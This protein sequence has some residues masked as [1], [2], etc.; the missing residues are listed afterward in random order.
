M[1]RYL[2]HTF[3]CFTDVHSLHYSMVFLFLLLSS[4][5]LISAQQLKDILKCKTEH[6]ILLLS[7]FPSTLESNPR[8]LPWPSR[9]YQNWSKFISYYSLPRSFCSAT[10]AFLLFYQCKEHTPPQHLCIECS[11]PNIYTACPLVLPVSSQISP[12]QRGFHYQQQPWY[13]LFPLTHFIIFFGNTI[14]TLSYS[15]LFI[16]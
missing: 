7:D 8:S 5:S 16:I 12:D 2:F 14:T 3:S 15:H 1:E 10:Q 13:S 11:S 9:P 4:Y 6:V